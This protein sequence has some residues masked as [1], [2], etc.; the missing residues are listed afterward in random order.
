[1][2]LIGEISFEALL[3]FDWIIQL[4]R[5]EWTNEIRI[6]VFLPVCVSRSTQFFSKNKLWHKT[7][8]DLFCHVVHVVDDIVVVVAA[9]VVLWSHWLQPFIHSFVL[10]SFSRITNAW[11]KLILAHFLF[12]VIK[13][14]CNMWWAMEVCWTKVCV[15]ILDW[16]QDCLTCAK[17]LYL[18]PILCECWNTEQLAWFLLAILQFSGVTKIVCFVGD[19]ILNSC[20]SSKMT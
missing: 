10:H 2:W 6:S 16:F 11:Q 13:T 9:A 7:G 15:F 3:W 5:S 19:W 17:G 14:S 20:E 18:H 8:L 1:M 12:L 4:S